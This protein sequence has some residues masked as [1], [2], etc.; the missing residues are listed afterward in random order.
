MYIESSSP[1]KMN[2][3]AVL[4]SPLIQSTKTCTMRFYYHMYGD[5][6]GTLNIYRVVGSVK[7]L[8]WTESGENGRRWIKKTIDLSASSTGFYVIIE[9]I[10][11]SSYKGDIAIDDISF[12]PECQPKI[13]IP[14][15]TPNPCSNGGFKCKGSSTCISSNKKCDFN[16][17]C[18]DHSDESAEVC[19]SPC[20]FETSSCGW[21][22]AKPNNFD[23]TRFHGCTAQSRTCRDASDN[24]AGFYMYVT[25]LTGISGSEAV[26]KS[27][28]YQK[29]SPTCV[30]EF[31]YRMT[32]T[33]SETLTLYLNT[34][35]RKTAIWKTAI[36][37]RTGHHGYVW[38]KSEVA[39]GGHTS[40]FTLTFE[41]KHDGSY[42]GDIAVDSVTMKNC[43]QQA[44]CTGGRTKK[45][46][47]NNN[48]CYSEAQ[49]CDLTNDCGD[50]TDETS[51]TNI[52]CNFDSG[53]C[54]WRNVKGEDNFDWT[55][56]QGSTGSFGT[57]PSTDHT[58]GK[59]YYMYIEVS[60]KRQGDKAWLVSSPMAAPSGTCTLRLWYHMK[61][62][63]IQDLNIWYRTYKGGPLYAVASKSGTMGDVWYKMTTT[64][65][66]GTKNNGRPFEVIIEGVRG[67]GYQGDVAVDDI[68]FGSD[69]QVSGGVIP[70][71]EVPLTT[72]PPTPK[73]NNCGANQFGCW[74]NGQCIASSKVCDFTLDC[75]DNS[76]ER[77]CPPT[78]DF[79]WGRCGWKEA[80]DDSDHFD[81]RRRKGS[82]PSIGTGPTTDHTTNSTNGYYLYIEASAGAAYQNA[83]LISPVFR[84]AYSQCALQLWYHMYGPTIGSLRVYLNATGQTTQHWVKYGDQGNK[85]QKTTIGIGKQNNPFRI[86]IQATRGQSY[87]GDIAID[88]LLFTGCGLPVTGKCRPEEFTCQRGSCTKTTYLCDFNDD[89]GDNSDELNCGNY[90]ARCNFQIDGQC[91]WTNSKEDDFDW[92][93]IKGATASFNTGPQFDHTN[94][95]S[96]G[97]YI[98]LETSYPR[99]YGDKAWYISPT[100]QS[101]VSLDKCNLRFF[102]HMYGATIGQLNVYIRT[103]VNGTLGKPLWSAKSEQG[104]VWKRGSVSL[105]SQ[106]PFEVV[107][108]GFV[109]DDYRGDIALDD[110]SFTAECVPY[111]GTLPVQPDVGTTVRPTNPHSCSPVQFNCYQS[112]SSTCVSKQK[113]CD[114][115]SDCPGGED[116]NGCVK[117]F[118]NFNNGD[119][120][121][122]QIDVADTS[123]GGSSRRL[124]ALSYRWGPIQADDT[125]DPNL[126]HTFNGKPYGW[127]LKADASAAEYSGSVTTLRSRMIS[128]TGPQCTLEFWYYM[129][130]SSV[131][132]LSL[133]TNDIGSSVL[134]PRSGHQGSQWKKGMVKIG[135]RRNFQVVFQSKSN[136]AAHS[137]INLD[138][139]KF[140][141]C[142][143]LSVEVPCKP[144]VEFQCELGGCT[145]VTR[146]CDY[147]LDCM[148]GD[149]SDEMKCDAYP[150]RCDFE[151]GLCAWEQDTT[152]EF[153]WTRN[154]GYTPSYSTG[155]ITD[156]TTG[157]ATGHYMY[158]ETSWPRKPGDRA[159]LIT[160][161]IKSESKG[162]RLRFYYHMKGDHIGWLVVYVRKSYNDLKSIQ[163]LLNITGEQDDF[164]RRAD[165]PISSASE[166]E[167]VIEGVRGTSYTGDISI[168]DVSLTP[169][170]KVCPKCTPI[171]GKPSPTP[172]GPHTRPS[173]SPCTTTQF[174]CQNLKCVEREQV[175]DF[176][177]SCGDNSDEVA[178]G[179]SCTFED[180]Y[181]YQGWR[182]PTGS[183]NTDWIRKKGPPQNFQTGPKIDHTTGTETGYYMNFDSFRGKEGTK[184]QLV[185]YRY[186]AADPH[187]RMSFWYY[188]AG[189]SVGSLSVKLK[190][191][192]KSKYM[193]LYELKK[194]QGESWKNANLSIKA[195]KEFEIIF[196]AS[197]GQSYDGII[198]LD[199]IKFYNCFADAARPCNENELK[200]QGAHSYCINR[201]YKVCDFVNDCDEKDDEKNC[202]KEPNNCNFDKDMCNFESPPGAKKWSRNTT[203]SSPGT[204]TKSDHTTGKGSFIFVD[205]SKFQP[206]DQVIL[207]QKAP[208]GEIF[209]PGDGVCLMRFYYKMWGSQHMGRLQ[210]FM[211][212]KGKLYNFKSEVWKTRGDV[213]NANWIR[214]DVP[215]DSPQ[216]FS[217]EFVATMG[218]GERGDIVLDDISFSHGCS[219]GGTPAP[220]VTRG[221]DQCPSDMFKCVR[222]GLCIPNTWKCDQTSDCDDSSDEQNCHFTTSAPSPTK[223]SCH[224]SLYQCKGTTTCIPR[225]QLC[226]HVIDCTNQDDELQDFCELRNEDNKDL[227]YC[228]PKK[229]FLIAGSICDRKQDC[230]D[231][232]DE[233]GCQGCPHAFCQNNSNCITS[234]A[235]KWTA[236]TCKC[237]KGVTGNR[238]QNYSKRCPNNT[239]P[240]LVKGAPQ[241][242]LTYD[243]LCD[244]TNDCSNGFDENKD[245]CCALKG[246]ECAK[247]GASTNNN[248]DKKSWVVPVAVVAAIVLTAV[249]LIAAY[250]LVKRRRK[251]L[252]LFSV[253]YDPNRN[254][255]GETSKVPPSG[256]VVNVSEG[257]GNP[258]Y[259]EDR[260][261][262]GFSMS[263]VDTNMFVTDDSFTVPV[264]LYAHLL[265]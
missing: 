27:P 37:T 129:A 135:S 71:S 186:Y 252:T 80:A 246:I 225:Y 127:Y 152:D 102:Y 180:D 207:R 187:C 179:T 72:K 216:K 56:N 20:T 86:I 238:C 107:I 231:Y 214:V 120:G 192:D 47:N 112:G 131:G 222:S 248:T 133:L 17:D 204:G 90:Q 128:S 69:C 62:S 168:D 68:S 200:C 84:K 77:F 36:W 119:L 113:V 263:D 123:G 223:F 151:H 172:F 53:L 138:D 262:E 111:S 145:N 215:L 13:V 171:D 60:G 146:V 243:Q 35:S 92:K 156:H 96:T 110:L 16:Y 181:C 140:T 159:R 67:N 157:Q 2:D 97:Y 167:I 106:R 78:C 242:C 217:I 155:P 79:E 101:R 99:R 259:D 10:T 142:K 24:T 22:E 39:V 30:F 196:E 95:D 33:F 38:H 264:C 191:A 188:M 234:S 193:V 11:G 258:V 55:R 224:K 136:K 162:C 184:A 8:L 198:A 114:F 244:K 170:C 229:L 202:D 228:A 265:K 203:T 93:R 161:V 227:Y 26:L 116:E 250:V 75:P 134:W 15:P 61:G 174:A 239:Y 208:Q 176:K 25:S 144:T 115:S 255:D 108:E 158:T 57:G 18:N 103:Y 6:I 209:A 147:G 31:Y 153:D 14:T 164:W 81:W 219:V 94:S 221:P 201:L 245:R 143:P 59:G 233:I 121:N 74:S 12:T 236:P 105:V 45:C 260:P 132:T 199:D 169:G 41:N 241:K 54:K 21:N 256:G 160:P 173:N 249:V 182:N 232:G 141:N 64:I 194:S 65:N 206:F 49:T 195:H 175:C 261:L 210:L 247:S 40:P 185:S 240:C 218:S 51:C 23:W 251:K 4:K 52:R 28:V 190:L 254:Q 177:D 163:V 205:S 154:T 220:P 42:S 189:T 211:V 50:N 3:T 9:G 126:D 89:C 118:S 149:D 257:I 43:D 63:R 130:G 48:Y 58:T 125:V 137:D 237:P 117:P 183:D 91:P 82:T 165:V 32:S 213:N 7:S 87:S 66:L 230:L 5:H 44:S 178:C 46:K 122:W 73:P 70:T 139:I 150:G 76:D 83:K 212:T 226:D 19:G 1:R 29:S 197:R 235:D 98:Y 34:G 88:D 104:S 124:L 85:W 166:F 100:F 148:N 253:F 109:G